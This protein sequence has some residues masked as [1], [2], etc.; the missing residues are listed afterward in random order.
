MNHYSEDTLRIRGGDIQFFKELFEKYYNNLC[1]L[2]KEY[3]KEDEQAEEI[4]EEL[5][6]NLW[7]KRK[8]L[9]IHTSVKIYLI[10]SVQNRCISYL[11]K[12]KTEL[13]VK[14]EISVEHDNELKYLPL[15]ESQPIVRL[16]T[17]ELEEKV[18]KEINELPEQCRKIFELSRFEEKSYTEISKEL[19]ISVNTVKTQ[20]K[21]ALKKLRDNLK[22][23]LP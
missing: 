15:K 13:K 14:G 17:N 23:F 8:T 18:K 5:F 7:E 21:I 19:S 11:R 1:I 6:Y 16:F 10:R 4:V 9:D 22:E 3:V 2:A 12:L 20:M